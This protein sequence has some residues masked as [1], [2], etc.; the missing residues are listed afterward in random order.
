MT[1]TRRENEIAEKIAFGLSEKEIANKLCLAESTVHTHSKNIRKKIAGRSAVDVAR[2][3]I[4]ENPKKF[5]TA[6]LLLLLQGYMVF[7]VQDINVR[8][9]IKVA[10][11]TV[12]TRRNEA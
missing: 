12:K 1:L 10:N 3:Y 11:R 8:Q 2:W 7:T 6:I 4:I 9:P 5:F